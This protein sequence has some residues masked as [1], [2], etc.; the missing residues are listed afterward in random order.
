MV[1]QKR[2]PATAIAGLLEDCS[3]WAA[4]P[5]RSSKAKTEAQGLVAHLHAD[6]RGDRYDVRFL[7]EVIVR[8]SI[9]PELD[10]ARI[11]LARGITGSITFIDDKTGK[12]RTIV[13]IE[14]A[15]KLS[16]AEG[17]LRFVKA[18]E[19]RLYRSPAAETRRPGQQPI[20]NGFAANAA[21]AEF[22][23]ATST[24]T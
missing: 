5:P 22:K 24:S 23:C 15:A 19:R 18:N 21:P 20:I 3:A 7:G 16:V 10:A 1:P 9:Q 14:A 6:R 17:P 4:E 2:N 12:S 13:N 8:R 11:L